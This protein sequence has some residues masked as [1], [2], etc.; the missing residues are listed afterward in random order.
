MMQRERPDGVDWPFV[1]TVDGSYIPDIPDV[2]LSDQNLISQLSHRL[3]CAR[4]LR[5]KL[6]LIADKANP[7]RETLCYCHNEF[8]SA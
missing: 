2:M 7:G 3:A 5:K 6:T 1:P 8:Y 4:R